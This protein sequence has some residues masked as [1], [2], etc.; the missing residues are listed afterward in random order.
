MLV[1]VSFYPLHARPRVQR[2]SGIPCSLSFGGNQGQSSGSS[3]R[4]IAELYLVGP[5]GRD[6][7]STGVM[8]LDPHPEEPAQRASRRMKA[9]VVPDDSPGD[10]KHRPETPA[11]RA[12]HHE[13]VVPGLATR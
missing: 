4:E 2:A 12:T 1:C 7:H 6:G 5:H 10:A 9:T 8:T 11:A 3:C 13:G